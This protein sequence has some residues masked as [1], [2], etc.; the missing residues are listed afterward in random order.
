MYIHYSI[1]NNSGPRTL[2]CIVEVSVIGGVHFRRFHC[3]QMIYHRGGEPE[4][5]MHC[6][7][8][9]MAH[10]PWT[11]AAF[12]TVCCSMSVVSNTLC[13]HFFGQWSYYGYTYIL[14]E[15]HTEVMSWISHA[16]ECRLCMGLPEVNSTTVHDLYYVYEQSALVCHGQ[17]LPC[18]H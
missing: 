14:T 11:T 17:Q 15:L 7:I 2:V 6:W 18:V 1:G 10:K 16:Y 13:S 8:N 9:V 4:W 12:D 3:S 5:A